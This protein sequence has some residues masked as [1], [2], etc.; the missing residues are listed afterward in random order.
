MTDL[1]AA[2]ETVFPVPELCDL[3]AYTEAH[4]RALRSRADKCVDGDAG[5]RKSSFC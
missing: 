5:V 4:E 1:S 3:E 2:A